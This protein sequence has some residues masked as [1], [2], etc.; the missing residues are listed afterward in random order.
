MK[1]AK[2]L[3]VVFLIVGFAF[4]LVQQR[5]ESKMNEI[6]MNNLNNQMQVINAK[7]REL[8]YLIE[9]EVQRISL[10][11]NNNIGSPISMKDIIFIDIPN[12][13]SNATENNSVSRTNEFDRFFL[14]M[15]N[16]VKGRIPVNIIW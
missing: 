5:L 4:L 7:K 16:S 9:K 11:N 1:Y 3:V 15:Y 6:Q 13:F 8:H 10:Y 14:S 12:Q 2:Y